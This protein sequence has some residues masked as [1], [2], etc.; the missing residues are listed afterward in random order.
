MVDRKPK[1]KEPADVVLNKFL[2][3][4]GILLGMKDLPVSRG[5]DGS[6]TI[7]S[8]QPTAVYK[9]DVQA[10]QAAK[11]AKANQPVIGKNG[12]AKK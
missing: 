4:S 6:V 12:E 3:K 1:S 10:T 9:A 7:R 11:A 8:S 2:E 5:T